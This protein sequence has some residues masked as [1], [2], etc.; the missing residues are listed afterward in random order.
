MMGHMWSY[1][2]YLSMKL[3][4]C[5]KKDYLDVKNVKFTKGYDGQHQQDKGSLVGF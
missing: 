4:K 5:D 2:S 3:A 1:G